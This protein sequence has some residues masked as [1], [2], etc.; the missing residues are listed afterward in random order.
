MTT[1]DVLKK[2]FRRSFKKRRDTLAPDVVVF[3]E[4]CVLHVENLR[5]NDMPFMRRRAVEAID[6][7]S[8]ALLRR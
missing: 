8:E 3:G 5:S 7:F 6:A 4:A 2:A 1:L